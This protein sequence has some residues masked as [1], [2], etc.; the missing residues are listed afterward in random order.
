M[1]E[2][3]W[4]LL[5]PVEFE[6][7]LVIIQRLQGL[8]FKVVAP[9]QDLICY[10]EEWRVDSPEDID[11]LDEWP[12]EDVTLVGTSANWSGDFYLLAGAYHSAYRS[13]QRTDTYCSVSHPWEIS[14]HMQTHHPQGMFWVG[15]RGEQHTFIRVRLHTT[16]IISPG[17]TRA[18]HER[19]LWIQERGDAFLMA[20]NALDIP[21][22][23][24]TAN[25]KVTL[26]SQNHG[27]ALFCSWPDAFGP[28]QFEYNVADPFQFLI[29]A[30][31]L[32]KTSGSNASTVRAYMTGFTP[33]ALR[34]FWN[35]QPTAQHAYRCCVHCQIEDL[36]TIQK[37]IQPA[38]KLYANITEFQTQDLLPYGDDAWAVVGVVAFEEQFKVEVRLNRAPLPE[39]DMLSWL[40]TLIGCPMVYAPLPPFP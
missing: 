22:T 11:Q 31:Q 8:G 39:A 19:S 33:E 26:H 18:D 21:V 34:D 29:P 12:V 15:F 28:C 1:R 5:A 35:V 16:D 3:R 20:I 40:D 9:N 36:P 23:L 24:S 27:A 7:V 25:G 13:H 37:L 10:V 4:E 30:T 38:G 32:A 17:E 14:E 2:R 6:Q